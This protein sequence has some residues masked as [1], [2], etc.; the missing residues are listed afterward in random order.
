MNVSSH[1]VDVTQGFGSKGQVLVVL[2]EVV[3]IHN[4][5]MNPKTSPPIVFS[6]P[7]DDDDDDRPIS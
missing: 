4:V 6:S 2:L 7:D 5:S 3:D 1:R